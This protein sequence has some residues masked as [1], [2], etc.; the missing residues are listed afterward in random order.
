M[1]D[2]SSSSLTREKKR[3]ITEKK[4]LAIENGSCTQGELH[5]RW[6]QDMTGSLGAPCS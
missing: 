1:R 4:T 5:E 2:K 6:S 3:D